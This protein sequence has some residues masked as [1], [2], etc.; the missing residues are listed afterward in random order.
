MVALHTWMEAEEVTPTV[1]IHENELNAKV[2]RA[3]RHEEEEL[4]IKSR[5]LW[6]KS[7]DNNMTYFHNQTKARQIYNFIREIKDK[8]WKQD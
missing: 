4:R 1:L 6:F 7:G 5:Q 2:L 8:K 3:E